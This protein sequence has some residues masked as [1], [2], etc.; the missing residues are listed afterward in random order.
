MPMPFLDAA[1]ATEM[2]KVPYCTILTGKGSMDDA[3]AEE[4]H[5]SPKHIN[6]MPRVSSHGR[7]AAVSRILSQV[8]K[9]KP[10]I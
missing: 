5:V 7:C 1:I 6:D 10:E 9:C 2:I 4:N 3:H 8:K